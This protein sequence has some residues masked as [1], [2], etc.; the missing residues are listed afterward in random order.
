MPANGF[1]I[2]TLE[3]KLL[4]GEQ[5]ATYDIGS[6]NS[7]IQDEWGHGLVRATFQCMYLSDWKVSP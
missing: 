4:A 7:A 3:V 6:Q 1:S 2:K 5:K